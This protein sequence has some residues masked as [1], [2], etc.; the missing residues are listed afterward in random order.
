MTLRISLPC[1]PVSA[2]AGTVRTSWSSGLGASSLFLALFF[3]ANIPMSDPAPTLDARRRKALYR[4]SYRGT[5]EMD[6]L[7]G[8]YAEAKLPAMDD[9]ALAEFEQFLA[10]QDPDLNIW[11]LNP[12]RITAPEYA[13]LVEAIRAFHAI[14]NTLD[15]PLT[16]SATGAE[17]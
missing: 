1:E 15:R 5:K 14:D 3:E 11:I 12:A 8:R 10:L 6:W 7:L 2:R 17:R 9:T 13:P 4:A 16:S